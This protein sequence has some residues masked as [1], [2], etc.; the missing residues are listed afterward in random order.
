MA[1]QMTIRCIACGDDKGTTKDKFD[2]LTA[3]GK[4]ETYLCRSC[5]P[6]KTKVDIETQKI[7]LVK[8]DEDLLTNIPKPTLP[9]WMYNYQP[10]SSDR[11][12]TKDDFLRTDTCFRPD[13]FYGNKRSNNDDGSCDGC[14]MFDY[15]GCL[16]KKMKK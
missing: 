15:C 2:E 1:A 13:I 10:S 7:P 9:D 5:R 8:M 4:I 3:A 12:L 6:K 16:T 11:R 14:K